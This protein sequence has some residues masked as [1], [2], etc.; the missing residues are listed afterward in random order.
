MQTWLDAKLSGQTD[1]QVKLLWAPGGTKYQAFKE[2]PLKD[3]FDEWLA[4]IVAFAFSLPATPFIKQMNR[5][6]GITDQD[7]SEEEGL[8]PL[9]LW[10]KR[11]IDGVIQDD[12]GH[13]DLEF[14]WVDTPS[15]DP[16]IQAEIDSINLKNGTV[17]I[18]EVRDS[19]GQDPLPDGLGEKPFLQIATGGI[20]LEQ[21]WDASDKALNPPEP[22]SP[23]P[24]VPGPASADGAP[25]PTQAEP[26]QPPKGAP[27]GQGGKPADHA[28]KDTPAAKLAKA[29]K[30]ISATRPKARR[31]AVGIKKAL[32]PILQKAGDEVAAEVGRKLRGMLKAADD[33]SVAVHMALATKLAQQADLSALDAATDAI[34][35]DLFEIAQDSALLALGSV[36]VE[37]TDDITNQVFDRAVTYAKTRAAQLVS[38]QGPKNIVEATRNQIR[39]TVAKGLE[40]NIGAD[41]IAE[42]IQESTAFSA[43]RADLIA[44]TEISMANGAGKQ[45]GWQ[46]A[47]DTGL[48]LQ[49]YWQTSNNDD[50]CDDCQANEDASPL[51]FGDSFPSGDS[52]APAHPRCQCV[53]YAEASEAGADDDGE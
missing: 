19:R 15:I 41:A 6:T 38:L 42:A 3:D 25:G 20:T 10:A 5:S 36:H 26:Q 4:R 45:E 33:G 52:D 53:T 47:A 28:G 11:L 32:V 37:A 31:A 1:E 35:D 23:M 16:K 2:S 27:K 24:E 44:R 13:D 8:E 39:D 50:C 46:A 7:R 34:Y 40:D 43:E 22:P 51:P 9:K 30:L 49:V 21:I 18:D 12:F 29:S 17:S 14:V 48:Q